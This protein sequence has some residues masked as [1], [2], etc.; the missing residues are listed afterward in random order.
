MEG[1]V[2]DPAFEGPLDVVKFELTIPGGVA[3]SA[4]PG[5]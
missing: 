4:E 3:P 2:G 1:R 5:S